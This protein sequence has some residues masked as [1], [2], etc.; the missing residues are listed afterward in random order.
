MSNK[1]NNLMLIIIILLVINTLLLLV[2]T[3]NMFRNPTGA[4]LFWG[5]ECK[6]DGPPTVVGEYEYCL[7]QMQQCCVHEV[8]M[9]PCGTRW[10]WNRC[11]Y[12]ETCD[13]QYA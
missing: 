6:M 4:G 7:G 10:N 12:C 5:P 9:N 1:E 3:I 2:L 13:A 11:A 8:Y